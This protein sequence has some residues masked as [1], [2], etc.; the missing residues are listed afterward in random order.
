MKKHRENSSY[1]KRIFF[2][3]TGATFF[4]VLL[5]LIFM[6][7]EFT[8]VSIKYMS[9]TNDKFLA[10][11]AQTVNLKEKNI[12]Q[13]IFSNLSSEFGVILTNP[14]SPTSIQWLS[15]IHEWDRIVM[16]DR[17]IHS[18]NIY[19]ESTQTIATVGA[20]TSYLSV[21]DTHDETLLDIIDRNSNSGNRIVRK[22]EKEA[23][24]DDYCEVY[25]YIIR[26]FRNGKLQYAVVVNMLVEEMF[27]VLNENISFVENSENNF[28]VLTE[29]DEVVFRGGNNLSVR[30]LEQNQLID[31]L[32]I[33]TDKSYFFEEI[34]NEK[35]LFN[36]H[37]NNEKEFTYLNITPYSQ[38]Y[39][40]YGFNKI[41][42]IVILVTSVIFAICINFF[43]TR[44]LYNPIKR[45]T[46]ELRKAKF[47]KGNSK[48][49]NE[50]SEIVSGINAASSTI[51][52]LFEYKEKTINLMQNKLLREQLVY[53][54]YD[55]EEFFLQCKNK[56][57]SYT[58]NQKFIL[59]LASWNTS[60]GDEQFSQE[61][62]GLLNYA[63]VNVFNEILEEN[64]TIENIDLEQLVIGFIC[65]FEGESSG[66]EN[67]L[68][69]IQ[70][71]FKEYFKI[72]LAFVVSH[73]LQ[74]PSEFQDTTK[75]LLEKMHYAIFSNYVGIISEKEF[76]AD[77]LREG[78][79]ED[80]DYDKLELCIRECDVDQTYK[81]LEFYFSQLKYYR[82]PSAISSI[83]MFSIK[84]LQVIKHIESNA[85]I[86]FDIP[87]DE[88]YASLV[89][90]KQLSDVVFICNGIIDKVTSCLAENGKGTMNQLITKIIE[91]IQVNYSDINL[92]SKELANRSHVS[93]TNLNRLY[94]QKTGLGIAAYIKN[95]R[96]CKSKEILQSTNIPV[97][98]IAL[99]VGFE[100]TKYFYS[101]FKN[102]YG[103][104]PS[105]FRIM[106]STKD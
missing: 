5:A 92:S 49:S 60:S 88:L 89:Q 31:I 83:G 59:I 15:A 18:V 71:T 16:Q 17:N 1:F 30:T 73:D 102:E 86:K 2:V 40:M 85:I 81:L 80:I 20:S 77:L 37:S 4:V 13:N 33:N 54:K 58:K 61:D 63:I 9:N 99:N 96:L 38:I 106:S 45:I 79:C 10:D 29:K 43:C 19:N 57:I 28:F 55:D 36:I 74:S 44:F 12:E 84:F 69:S 95:V 104:S 75:L 93:S 42:G 98:K 50:L 48:Q 11:V 70:I 39:K 67:Q 24:S 87:Y 32:Q 26:G 101:V 41:I 22:V 25:S 6:Y 53:S 21:E 8:K 14:K 78:I 51:E 23:Y 72:D 94:K 3:M 52:R 47:I 105:N 7:A 27:N 100:N 65:G 56:E 103:I 82:Y 91:E 97:E 76:Q 64:Y 68:K 90:A 46:K 66:I 62:S 35:F 34:N